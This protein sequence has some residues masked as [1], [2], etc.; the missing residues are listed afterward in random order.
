MKI[1]QPR[2]KALVHVQRKET[3]SQ[4]TD[5]ALLRE[6]SMEKAAVRII[7]TTVICPE[8]GELISR[9]LSTAPFKKGKVKTTAIHCEGCRSIIE[10]KI[11]RMGD[12]FWAPLPTKKN[13]RA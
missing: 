13:A 7:S 12:D 5:F 6:S 1:E 3:E 10:V 11:S 8:C 9:G 4:E 2:K